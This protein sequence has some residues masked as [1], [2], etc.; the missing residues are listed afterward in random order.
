MICGGPFQPPPFCHSG[1]LVNDRT[2]HLKILICFSSL[3]AAFACF[4]GKLDICEVIWFFVFIVIYSRIT[5]KRNFL[6]CFL[7]Q[8]FTLFA[9][10]FLELCHVDALYPNVENYHFEVQHV[11]SSAGNKEK[12][13]YTYTLSKGYTEEK[14]YGNGFRCDINLV[15]MKLGYYFSC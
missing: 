8:A 6:S 3:K 5:S 1:F 13:A 2:H 10:H 11:R 9:T 7:I 12:I 4:R 14:N 15:A